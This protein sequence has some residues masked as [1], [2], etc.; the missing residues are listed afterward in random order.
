MLITIAFSLA[1]IV[2]GLIGVFEKE[3]FRFFPAMGLLLN[4]IALVM[5]GL[6]IYWGT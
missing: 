6:I 2:L 3:R 4:V 5:T 1:G